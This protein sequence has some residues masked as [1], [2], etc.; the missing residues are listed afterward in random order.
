MY[1]VCPRCQKIHPFNQECTCAKY[2][3]NYKGGDERNLRRKGA[4]KDKSL[5]IRDKA[6]N[7][8][9]V[10]KDKG[11]FIYN[12]LSVHHIEKIKDAPEKYLDNNNLI[13]LCSRCHKDADAGLIDKSYLLRLAERREKKL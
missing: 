11:R 2:K 7:L 12:N 10:C 1:K 9:E 3:K 8:C 6:N 5:E 13:C 4:W